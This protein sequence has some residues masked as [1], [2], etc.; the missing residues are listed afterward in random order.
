MKAAPRESRE[1]MPQ[2]A[3]LPGLEVMPEKDQ[4]AIG[5]TLGALLN[6]FGQRNSDLLVDVY[7]D[8]ADWMN[9]FGTAKTGSSQIIEYLKGLFAD[10]NF[11]AGHPV[12]P[13]EA[14]LRRLTD[15]VVIVSTHMKIRGQEFVGG[16]ESTV[17]DN[18][19]LHVLQRQPDARW[20][21]VSE[22]FM[23]SRTDQT[24]VPDS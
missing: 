5:T 12:A 11:D 7:A 2:D 18:H 21:V 9:A 13:P 8:D 23:D 17:R 16:G 3:E 19:A 10:A 22:L 15:D 20:L 1:T 24:Y 4:E 6:G 14:R